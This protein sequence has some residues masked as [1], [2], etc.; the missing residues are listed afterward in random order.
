MGS[1]A[2]SRLQCLLLDRCQSV[3]GAR[4]RNVSG[5]LQA[6]CPELER[7]RARRTAEWAVSSERVQY[8]TRERVRAKKELRRRTRRLEILREID[9]AILE[10]RSP[11]AI[12]RMGLHHVRRLMPCLGG[13]VA[14][15][16]LEIDEILVL[17]AE[18]DGDAKTQD[19]TRVWLSE[20][21]WARALVESLQQGQVHVVEDLHAISEP[22]PATQALQAWGLRAL[23]NVPLIAEGKLIGFLSLGAGRPGRFALDQVDLA[24]EVAQLLATAIQQARLFEKIS[25]NRERMR[26]L[27]RKLV[28]AQ[29]EERRRLSRALHD[30][31]GQA[32]TAL[33]ISLDL[34]RDDLPPELDP[35]VQRVADASALTE[36]TLAQLR[37]LAQDLRPPALDIV[38]LSPALEGFCRHFSRRTRISITYLG[39]DG[40]LPMLPEAVHICLYRFLQEALTNVA[41]HARADQVN[42]VLYTGDREIRLSVEDDGQGFDRRARMSSPGWPMGIGLWGMQERVESLGGRLDLES[43]LGQG[44]RLVAHI[45]LQED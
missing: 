28:S 45:P 29:E 3:A 31:A 36:T 35:L 18:V 5:T 2:R 24:L 42:V 22:S 21:K 43:H 39:E 17:A 14:M 8:E 30:E 38:G 4:C 11:S 40:D 26:Q 19:E 9:Q 13:V 6:S 16:D 37:T 33:K 25:L 20:L 32:L 10:A 12:A 1:A 27:A 15:L 34:I 44:T 23:L 41:K 7:Q